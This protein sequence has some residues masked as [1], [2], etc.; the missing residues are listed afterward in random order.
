MS[1]S[2]NRFSD[3]LWRGFTERLSVTK[4]SQLFTVWQQMLGEARTRILLWYLLILGITFLVA[5]P[6]FRYQI[7][8][9]IDQRVLQDMEADIMA[10]QA[11]I[12]GKSF[13]PENRL[14]DH[15][16]DKM[17][18]ES[19]QLK[20]LDS[21]ED[22][23]KLFR[24]YLLYRLPED[25]SYL[26][27]FIDGEFYKSS[28]S[29]R[30]KLL[31]RDSLLMREWA[32]QTQPQR[33][34]KEFFTPK[35]SKIL[36]MVEPVIINGETRGIFVV[37]HNTAG[38]REEA[39][40]AVSVFVEAASLVFILSLILTWLA[41]GRILAPL[42]I[43]ITTAHAISES[44]LTQRLPTRDRGELGELA[45]TFNEMMDRLE[46]AFA[47]Q[48]EFVND[49]GHELRTPITIIRGHL[50]LMG[51][52]PQE[53]Q[54]TLALVISELDRMS[55]LVDDLILLAK[56]ERADFLQVT[57]VN[58]AQLTEELF[59][60]AQ[61]LAERDWQLDAVAKGQIVVDR[62]RITE[63]VINLAQN[64]TQHTGES[65]TI[66]IGSAIA[67]GKVRFWVHDTGEGIPLVDQKR[68]F[69]R[70]AR[71]SNSRR[72][73]E[74][75]GLGLSIVRAIAESHDGEVLLRSQLGKGSMFTIVLP[76]DPPQTVSVYAQYSHR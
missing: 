6:A 57:T 16:S 21:G 20:R 59:V 9:R 19:R 30:P 48:R 28:P 61:A 24:A 3:R 18:I 38:E 74:G 26:I 56:A 50:E 65:D 33:G 29:A 66:S 42:G 32:K 68:I 13:V 11:L 47:S 76:L 27:T 2:I 58:V 41:A 37:A 54:E 63:A 52:D 25:E 55:R 39:L 10:F 5:I 75:A 51:D 46:A 43:I 34:E 69:E 7:Y 4:I 67:K 35:F 70:F 62:Q 17:V 71:T 23:K 60:K 45:K 40:E 12:D 53:Q 44:D 15:N 72:R 64:A 36:Y 31:A 49:A 1:R 8:Q 22:L 73:S 14:T